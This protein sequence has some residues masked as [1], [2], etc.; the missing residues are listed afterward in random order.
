MK[1]IRYSI[2]C[3]ILCCVVGTAVSEVPTFTPSGFVSLREGQVVSGEGFM[4]LP[5][6]KTDHVWVQEL[7]AGMNIQTAFNPYPAIGN[8]GVEV[9]AFNDYP[10]YPDDNGTTR[11]LNFYP[12]LSRAD[13]L[14]CF[15][16]RE[17]PLVTLD[18]G[19]FPF[20]Y[21]EDA[22][23]L[24]EYLFRSGTY[25]QYLITDFDFP[26][27][28]LLGLRATGKLADVFTWNVLA[29]MNW[30][31]TA[32][33]DLNLSAILSY[34]P[35]PF[36]DLGL[37]GSW[38]SAVSVNMDNTTPTI[39]GNNDYVYN[40]KQYYYTFAGHK[41]MGRFSLDPQT[42]FPNDLFGKQDFKL[43]A[44][45]AV[46]GVVNYPKSPDGKIDYS[47]ITKRIP[48]MGGFNIPAFKILDVLSLEAEWFG[49]KY[50]NDMAPIVFDNS[51]VP[52][53]STT[54][55]R[56][57]YDPSKPHNEDDWK[58]SIYGKKTIAD[59]FNVTFQC[60]RDHMR[61]VR[62]SYPAEDWREAL[63]SNKDWYYTIKLGYVF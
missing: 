18:I 35:V 21:N 22:R 1:Q 51:P 42:L 36:V 52:L 25:P 38:C 44:E 58:W 27:A 40:G 57:D 30:E 37:G 3:C 26:M 48:I 19:Y 28:R 47:D 20:K 54:R 29:T 12:Y 7:F 33:G 2:I 45:A 16:G 63:R 41:L 13:L 24:G 53:S 34:K 62:I 14:Y 6:A 60:A 5:K 9:R 59:H 50:V 10:E 4:S 31:W 46:L 23:N 49:S 17:N 11:R 55:T 43:Y 61:W 32:I 15:G 39:N 8:I 56:N